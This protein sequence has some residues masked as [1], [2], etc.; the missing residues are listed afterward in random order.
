MLPEFKMAARNG[1]TLELRD[2]DDR[3]WDALLANSQQS[4]I[5]MTSEYLHA[6]GMARSH[7]NKS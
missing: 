7:Y 5:F 2:C 4:N 6:I 1:R 3:Q